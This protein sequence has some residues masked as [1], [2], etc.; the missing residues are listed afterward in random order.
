MGERAAGRNDYL[1][2]GVGIIQLRQQF[3]RGHYITER[4]QRRVVSPKRNDVGT[5]ALGLQAFCNL[6]KRCGGTGFV[7]AVRLVV[8]GRAE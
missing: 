4:P 3:L 5:P 6:H 1:V 7:L 8:Q 2:K